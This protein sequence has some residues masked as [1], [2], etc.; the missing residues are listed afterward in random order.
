MC[1]Y[2]SD[3]E[4]TNRNRNAES[5]TQLSVVIPAYRESL[6]ITDTVKALQNT[7]YKALDATNVEIIVVDDGSNDGTSQAA[8]LAGADIV[9]SLPQNQGKGAAVRAG[10]HTSSGYVVA[11]TDADLAYSPDQIMRL[12]TVAASG[13]DVVVGSRNHP[14]A[15]ALKQARYLRN[16]GSRI[17][18]CAVWLL[19]L[20][21]SS[22]TQCG[23]KAFRKEAAQKIFSL[24]C[25]DGFAF[26]VELLYL[27]K[28]YG[29]SMVEVPVD[30]TNS[31]VSSVQVVRDGL[32][33]LK[34]IARIRMWAIRRQ[35]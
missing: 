11:F 8:S 27:T 14:D 31:S 13:V 19:G 3:L 24:S 9:V 30:V 21:N 25:I 35:Y 20:S 5:M 29:F 6:R 28:R 32:F 4:N 10:V 23:L 22:D 15:T 33:L 17:V 12:Y 34:D 2:I 18:R 26:D 16:I 7:L 1:S